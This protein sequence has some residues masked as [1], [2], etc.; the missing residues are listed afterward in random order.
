MYCKANVFFVI[1]LSYNKQCI[2]DMK[3]TEVVPYNPEWPKMFEVEAA[4][5]KRALGDNCIAIH[6]VGSTSVPGLKAKPKIDII[7]VVK[8]PANTISPLEEFGI[9][10]RGEYN[11]PQHYGFSKRGKVDV[12]LHIYAKG[13]PEIGLNLLFR[14]YLRSNPQVRDE[15]AILKENIL[16]DK[17]SLF[18]GDSNLP[19][20][21]LRKGSFIRKVLNDAGYDRIRMLKCSDETEWNA[22]RHFRQKFFFDKADVTDPYNWTFNHSEHEHLVLYQG[23]EIVGY[24][25]VQLWPENRA[26]LRIIVVDPLKRNLGHGKQFLSLIEDWLHSRNIKTLHT[27]SNPEAV[28]FYES[29]GYIQMP[30]ND[31]DGYPSDARDLPIGK[32]LNFTGDSQ[33][34]S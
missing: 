19:N 26:A 20:Y 17:T 10:Y 21:T 32:Q 28:K 2:L 29:C 34:A 22:A 33:H 1:M 11:I 31:P 6:H 25:H 18:R 23:T 24:A 27:E 8:E 4:I 12:N 13:H 3:K 9:Q 16:T 30:F 5:I 7:A 15:Y 14:D